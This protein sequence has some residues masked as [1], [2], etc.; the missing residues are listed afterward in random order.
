VTP[1]TTLPPAPVSTPAPGPSDE[2][3]VR[4]VIKD[5]QRAIESKD[6]ALY[7][8]LRSSLSADE[9]RKLRAA[10]ENVRSQEV[11]LVIESLS[12]EGSAAV[13]RVRRSGRINGQPV[14]TIQQVF[15][16]IKGPSG[17]VIRDI[18]Q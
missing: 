3:L 15:R 12:I 11:E 17:W 7:K 14:P 18:G 10:F 16:L 9:E 8:S 6:V 1:P 4:R 13:V 2:A 5:F